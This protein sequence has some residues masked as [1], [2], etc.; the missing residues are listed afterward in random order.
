MSINSHLVTTAG[1]L[2]ITQTERDVIDNHITALKNKLSSYF[3]KDTFEEQFTFGSYARKT[4]MPRRADPASD[5]DFMLVFK[6]KSY[7]PATYLRYLREFAVE[8][9]YSSEI[10]QSHPTI[11]L[12]LSK[13]KIE[14]VPSIKSAW[15]DYQIPAPSSNYEAWLTTHPTIFNATLS[16]KNTAE[17]SLIRPLVRIMK[18]WNAANDHVYS[19]YEL[20]GLIANHFYYYCNSLWDYFNSFV[21]SLST[22]GKPSYKVTKIEKLKNVVS[23]AKQLDA[24]GYPSIAENKLKEVIPVY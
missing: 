17:K 18:Y 8:K 2:I 19:S 21:S 5:V 12:E 1:S 4:L 24:N 7:Q 22:Y 6:N 20:E 16:S 3:D 23:E 15:D 9:Y 14:L 13:I 10:Y 11:V